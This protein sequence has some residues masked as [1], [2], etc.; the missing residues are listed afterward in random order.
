MKALLL[1]A[2]EPLYGDE[3]LDGNGSQ[4][5]TGMRRELVPSDR[6]STIGIAL[7]KEDMRE[8]MATL[9]REE[10]GL[11]IRQPLGHIE[12]TKMTPTAR[13][14]GAIYL[15]EDKSLVGRFD[16]ALANAEEALSADSESCYDFAAQLGLGDVWA[17][18]LFS[19]NDR[20]SYVIG[21]SERMAQGVSRFLK[22]MSKAD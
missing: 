15:L 8:H 17:H 6:E 3:S 21:V 18:H 16:C 9:L 1:E 19:G 11:D 13:F 20:Q 14:T 2:S 5:I 22:G 10:T 12:V 7:Y 4:S